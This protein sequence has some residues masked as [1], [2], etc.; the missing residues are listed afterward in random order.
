MPDHAN[1]P[2][3]IRNFDSEAHLIA[4]LEHPYVVPLFDYWR[5]LQRRTAFPV[6]RYYAGG[7][8]SHKILNEGP[9]SLEDTARILDQ[10][11]SALDAA[12]HKNIIHRDIKPANIML[13][14]EDNAY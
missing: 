10:I 2:K 14:S 13:D 7:S 11:A 9:L 3:F 4:R 1:N 8:L 5:E 6:A 12:H